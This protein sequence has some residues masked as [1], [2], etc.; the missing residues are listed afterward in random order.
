MSNLDIFKDLMKK[1]KYDDHTGSVELDEE[2]NINQDGTIN[3]IQQIQKHGGNKIHKDWVLVQFGNK[4][5]KP[6][7]IP[8][9]KD[10]LKMMEKR[11]SCLLLK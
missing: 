11:Q 2:K 4:K 5:K 1:K 7:K 10:I 9:V 3:Q 6:K 8:S